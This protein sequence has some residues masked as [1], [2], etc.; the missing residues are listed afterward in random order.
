[1]KKLSIIALKLAKKRYKNTIGDKKR[2]KSERKPVDLAD[3]GNENGWNAGEKMGGLPY[4]KWQ[5]MAEFFRLRNGMSNRKR[6]KNCMKRNKKHKK[7]LTI[8]S[9]VSIMN[10]ELIMHHA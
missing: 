8:L 1:V 2:S 7:G 9:L 4:F 6:N 5:K 3:A 10:T